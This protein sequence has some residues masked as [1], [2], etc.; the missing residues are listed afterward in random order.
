MGIFDRFRKKK[1]EIKEEK[2]TKEEEK[3]IKLY[4]EG[5]TKTRDNFVSKL[6]NL[7]NKHHK[8]I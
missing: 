1:E 6:V 2:I 3:E 8:I 4:D 5:L 7:T